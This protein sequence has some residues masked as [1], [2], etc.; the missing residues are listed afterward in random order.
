MKGFFKSLFGH[1]KEA[2]EPIS[3]R[4]IASI[5]EMSI[6]DILSH[7]A[8]IELKTSGQYVD[9]VK[10]LYNIALYDNHVPEQ[11][12]KIALQLAEALTA[13]I[14]KA[15]SENSD[16]LAAFRKAN[17]HMIETARLFGVGSLFWKII[18]ESVSDADILPYVMRP[19]HRHLVPAYLET[20]GKETV[21]QI[22]KELVRQLILARQYDAGNAVL[23]LHG[24][25]MKGDEAAT[26]LFTGDEYAALLAVPN[27]YNAG[28][29]VLVNLGL[30]PDTSGAR[31]FKQ[32][33]EIKT[34]AAF[35]LKERN[36][37][38]EADNRLAE[39]SEDQ[40]HALLLALSS[41]RFHLS[42]DNLRQIYGEAMSNSL[43]D[44]L[45]EPS[46]R[47]AM[48]EFGR[49]IHA[50]H[51]MPPGKP[52]DLLFLD[53]VMAFGGIEAKSEDDWSR[54][55]PFLDMGA[56]WLNRERVEFQCYLRFILRA[57]SDPVPQIKSAA[58]EQVVSFLQETYRR[59]GGRAGIAED[60]IYGEDWIGTNG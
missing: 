55:R 41:L 31:P 36:N 3:S 18:E 50:L 28:R 42:C 37:E 25:V 1:S 48:D 35:V 49:V 19:E 6:E 2:Q 47:E 60:A 23:I 59:E 51:G 13:D 16:G 38:A 15:L 20:V 30:L 14:E 45:T 10:R 58:D 52:G 44:I 22:K 21:L 5:E 8:S 53:S 54:N 24:L 33:A 46:T 57:M 7:A 4:P 27:D 39:L 29:R 34:A 11:H 43:M 17:E 56:E 40:R 26:A 12:R 9:L 32:I